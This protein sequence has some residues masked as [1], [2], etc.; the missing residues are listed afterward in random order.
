[1]KP[2]LAAKV[3]FNDL[4]KL[5]FPLLASPK[6]D[7]VRAVVQKD[8]TI[9]SRSLKIFPNAFT[10][11]RFNDPMLHGLDGELIVGSPS[12]PDAFLKTSKAVMTIDGSPNVKFH[13]FDSFIEQSH[14]YYD[15]FEKAKKLACRNEHIQLVEQRVVKSVDELTAMEVE[16]VGLGYEGIM[17]RNMDAPY[18]FGRSTFKEQF[19]VKLKRFEDSEAV[20][21]DVVQMH[22]NLNEAETDN[23]GH[24]VRSSKK[25]GMKP[26]PLVGAISVKDIKTGVQF[27]IGSGFTEGQRSELWQKRKTLS[28]L[29]VKYRYQPAGVKD[30]PRFPVFLGFRSGIDM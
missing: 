8:G 17:L 7:G 2:M 28:G 27:E 1:M 20:I 19:L 14:P 5:R 21:L 24:Q 9:T 30:K 16:Y 4:D 22:R 11:K 29:V 15:R 18:K 6:L 10:V 25:S 26:M 13:I 3:G 12:A 23:L